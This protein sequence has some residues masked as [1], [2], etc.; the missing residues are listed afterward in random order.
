MPSIEK[1]IQWFGMQSNKSRDHPV[2][3]SMYHAQMLTMQ[4]IA[5]IHS[6]EAN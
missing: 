3:Y 5:P 1:A 4:I 2:A 6:A